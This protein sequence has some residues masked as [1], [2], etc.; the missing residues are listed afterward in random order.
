[1]AARTCLNPFPPYGPVLERRAFRI[2]PRI[3]PWRTETRRRKWRRTERRIPRARTRLLGFLHRL[4]PAFPP[5]GR[6]RPCP[7]THPRRA[8]VPVMFAVE[9]LNCLAVHRNSP[10]FD[11]CEAVP[12]A[13]PSDPFRVPRNREHPG[14]PFSDLPEFRCCPVNSVL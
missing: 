10:P 12:A 1:M 6:S 14:F 7:E 5:Y 3:P 9:K 13:A 11:R 8:A 2:R 4:F